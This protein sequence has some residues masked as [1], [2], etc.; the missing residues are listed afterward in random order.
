MLWK[1]H[2]QKAGLQIINLSNP[3]STGQHY[4]HVKLAVTAVR[5]QVIMCSSNSNWSQW[6]HKYYYYHY[7]TSE[8]SLKNT[9]LFNVN[10]STIYKKFDASTYY[11]LPFFFPATHVVIIPVRWN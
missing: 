5:M 6:I 11:M 7:Y 1:L 10:V 3:I 8:Y 2:S 4:I 9:H